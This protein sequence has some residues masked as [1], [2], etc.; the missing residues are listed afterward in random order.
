MINATILVGDVREKLREL[1]SNLIQ[2]CITS[3]PYWGL[4]DYGTAS[5]EGG[6]P[7]C[8]HTISA[9][10]D[11]LRGDKNLRPESAHRGGDV[12]KCK[13]CG[14]IRIDNQLGLEL[15]PEAYVAN[16]VEVFR[17]VKRVLKDDGTLW[18]NLGDTYSAQR[19]SGNGAGQPMNKM[20]DG[21]RD[22]AP[23]KQAGLPDK[24]LVG[25][26]WRVAFALQADGW[27]LRQDI[28]WAKPNPMPESVKDRCTKSH[29]YLFLLT[30]SPKYYF[31]N[32]AIK[33]PVKQDWGIRNRTDGKYHNEGTGL[34]PHTGLT[35]SYDK[36]NKRDVWFITTKPFKGA[37][38][39]VMPEALVE[40]CVLAGSKD[41]D[42]V[43]DPFTGSGTVGVVANR[44]NRNFLGI[45]LNPDY[46]QIA[47]DRIGSN[48]FTKLI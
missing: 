19:W 35:K 16:M 29:E 44:H 11:T 18:L 22:I 30:K 1:E 21:H 12:S 5:Y 40:P 3:P 15:T 42:L 46:A 14:A 31:D 20:K 6:N 47:R 34:T 8:Q 26:P 17:E 7:D 27:Y 9:H 25:I 36:R 10:G 41:E 4:R 24:N 37:H 43:F 48:L 32:E 39:A 33:E 2:T 23:E 38:F 13:L 28:I 45:E